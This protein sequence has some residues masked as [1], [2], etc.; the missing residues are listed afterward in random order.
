MYTIL[1]RELK[2]K[3]QLKKLLEAIVLRYMSTGFIFLL[4]LLSRLGKSFFALTIAETIVI[5][6]FTPGIVC[7]TFVSNYGRKDIRDLNLTRL[8]LRNIFFGKLIMSNFY[9]AIFILFS[10][11][12][13]IIISFYQKIGILGFLYA[14]IT[15]LILMFT[16][17]M[18][19][20]FV[21]I[22]SSKNIITSAVIS[23]LIILLLL[24]SVIISGPLIEQT[25][26]PQ[27]RNN[28]IK[29]SLYANPIIMVSRSFGKID[30]LRTQYM[31]N[32]ADPIVGRGFIYPD[33]RVIGIIYMC[34]SIFLFIPILIWL[35]K[36]LSE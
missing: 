17:S 3:I 22:L 4:V 29:I 33:W 21:C 13:I 25:Q 35:S 24:G 5:L 15:L 2:N 27:V 19:S 32:L 31:Y 36:L 34:S 7:Y 10:A 11:I 23:Y 1:K 8:Q 20:L 9:N 12:V 18:I 14:N 16:T 26:N 28:I 6:F 30:I